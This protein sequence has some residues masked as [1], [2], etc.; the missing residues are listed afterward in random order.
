MISDSSAE[1]GKA[2]CFVITPIGGA[3]TSA[4]RATAGLIDAVLR[5]VLEELEY[6]VVAAHEMSKPGSITRQAIEHLL[7]ADMV[8]ANLTSLNPNVMYELAVRHAAR[9]PVVAV[10]EQG[11]ELPFDISDERTIFYANDLAGVNE[12]KLNLQEAVR[13]SAEVA[14]PDNPIYRVVT[15]RIMQ[16]ITSPGNTERYILERLESLEEAVNR[17]ASRTQKHHLYP[18]ERDLHNRVVLRA[19]MGMMF[20]KAKVTVQWLDKAYDLP[21]Y[22]VVFLNA[23]DF[24]ISFA[25]RNVA[26]E[27]HIRNWADEEDLEILETRLVPF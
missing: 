21:D 10:A 16:D 6:T 15:S 7:T 18:Q 11:T 14:E 1:S 2:V 26:D 17:A 23:T 9:L 12:L 5:P 20:E 3:D 27:V 4:R 22:R 19:R 25:C 8:V 13:D 24:R